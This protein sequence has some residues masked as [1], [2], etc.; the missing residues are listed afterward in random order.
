MLVV[1]VPSVGPGA[2]ESQHSPDKAHTVFKV[3]VLYNGRKHAIEKR[4]SEFHALHKR[5]KKLCKVPDFPPKRVPNWMTKVLEQ[6]RQGLEVY[7]Q[8]VVYYNE[9]L[10]KEVLDFLKLRHGYQDP[11]GS[12]LAFLLTH[13]PV[14]SFYKD[15]YVLPPATNLLPDT[16]LS[17]VLQGFYAPENTVYRTLAQQGFCAHTDGN[18]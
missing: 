14:L 10:P 4:Y 17:G 9:E 13:R 15:P 7:I 16:V 6:R 1:S 12:S 5:I 11:K 18:S 3:E 2:A 8:G